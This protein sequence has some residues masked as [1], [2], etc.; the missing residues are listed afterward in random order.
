MNDA[1][2]PRSQSRLRAHPIEQQWD[3]GD[4]SV[5]VPHSWDCDTWSMP[6][7]SRVLLVS[8]AERADTPAVPHPLRTH[9]RPYERIRT[10]GAV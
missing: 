5:G 6:S 9:P 10:L 3:D 8:V 4:R 1:I 2:G 7:E